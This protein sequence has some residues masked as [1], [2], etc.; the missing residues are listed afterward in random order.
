MKR[1][2]LDRFLILSRQ[3]ANLDILTDPILDEIGKGSTRRVVVRTRL[4]YGVESMGEARK[5]LKPL[6]PA[7]ILH[8]LRV[9][10]AGNLFAGSTPKRSHLTMTGDMLSAI[11]YRKKRDGVTLLFSKQWEA[12]KAAYNTGMGR[13]FFLLSDI[14]I[15]AVNQILEKAMD[16]YIDSLV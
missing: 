14:E 5:K 11:T 12:D 10:E 9:S 15:K 1:I 13:P 4:G 3:F 7:T 6:K 8:R 16:A 2:K